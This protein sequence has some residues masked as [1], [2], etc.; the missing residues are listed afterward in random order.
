MNSDR[1][2][3]A[4]DRD[5]RSARERIYGDATASRDGRK[6]LVSGLLAVG[7]FLLILTLSARQS[8][9]PAPAQRLIESGIAVTTDVDGVIAENLEPLRELARGSNAQVFAIPGYPLEV[10]LTRDELLNRTPAQIRDLVLSR[11]SAVVYTQGL[12]A[13]DRTGNQSLSRFSSQGLLEFGVGQLSQ[14][15][16]DR[17]S[18]ASLAL[19]LLVA[20]AA[21]GVLAVNS[22]WTR[23]RVLGTAT[24]VGALPGVLLFGLAWYGA[25]RVGGGDPFVEDLRGIARTVVAVPLRNYVVVTA[26]GAVLAASGILLGRVSARMA[27]DAQ[28]AAAA[29]EGFDDY[30]TAEP[31]G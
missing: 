16:N 31:E 17:A 5:F 6:A 15:T 4:H 12:G 11:S 18:M 22:G 28:A 13:F 30:V 20:V 26:L 29:D 9:D 3:A 8:T 1:R 7:V 10:F 23:V 25:G 19:A 24:L 27:G 14:S 21:C 2:D